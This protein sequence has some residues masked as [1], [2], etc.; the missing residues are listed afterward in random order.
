MAA[1]QRFLGTPQE[2][3]DLLSEKPLFA[4]PGHAAA[5]GWFALVKGGGGPPTGAGLIPAI[6]ATGIQPAPSHAVPGAI[7]VGNELRVA[8]TNKVLYIK[9]T[10]RTIAAYDDAKVWNLEFYNNFVAGSEQIQFL[11]W[12]HSRI[13]TMPLNNAGGPD[14]FMSGPFNGCHFYVTDPGG[15][16]LDVHHANA[17]KVGSN[18]DDS[19]KRPDM[20]ERYMDACVDAVRG[21]D[22]ILHQMRKN[23]YLARTYNAGVGGPIESQVTLAYRQ[24]KEGMGRTNVQLYEVMCL[25][26][27]Q[28]AAGNWTFYHHVAGVV[29]YRRSGPRSN[30]VGHL[31]SIIPC[32]QL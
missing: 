1:L 17:N 22:P 18:D 20:A 28:R 5:G 12:E 15:G 26:M 16:N 23:D 7:V 19:L 3:L 2:R 30:R 4:D 24:R 8:Q 11:S 32:R 27:G 6:Q 31:K 29:D 25:V 14:F 10:E 9:I 13:L 21:V